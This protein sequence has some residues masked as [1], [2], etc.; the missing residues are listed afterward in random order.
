MCTGDRP[1]PYVKL[2]IPTAPNGR[3]KTTVKYD[4][5]N[6]IWNETFLFYLDPV[7]QNHLRELQKNHTLNFIALR[8]YAPTWRQGTSEVK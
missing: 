3:R 1:D 8:P 7:V 5:K 2:F 6:P 4:T